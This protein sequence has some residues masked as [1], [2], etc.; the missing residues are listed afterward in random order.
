MDVRVS[1]VQCQCLLLL[2]DRTD[3]HISDAFLMA[4][5]VIGLQDE[6]PPEE[7]WHYRRCNNEKVLESDRQLLP[8]AMQALGH[9]HHGAHTSTTAVVEKYNERSR[10]QAPGPAA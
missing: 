6:A 7:S 2:C 4:R 8:M 10:L 5:R 3:A 9:M 1:S